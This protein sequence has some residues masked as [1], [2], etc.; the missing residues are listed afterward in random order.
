MRY[1]EQMITASDGRQLQVATLGEPTGRTVFF[2]HGTPGSASLVRTLAP[3]AESGELFVI[4]MSRAGYGTS[5]RQEGRTVANAAGDTTNVLDA[6]GREDYVVVGWSGGGP[7]ALACAALDAARCTAAWSIAG[8]VPISADIDWTEGMGPENLEEFALAMAGGPEYEPYVAAQA[9]HF[10]EATEGNVIEL[11]GGLLSD[12]DKATLAND[13]ARE[14]F[15]DSLRQGFSNGYFG[16]FDDDRAMLSEWGFDPATISIPVAVWYG[17]E[18][19]MVPSKHG[20]WLLRTLKN[21][22]EHHYPSEGH[23]SIIANHFDELTADITNA[24]KS[25]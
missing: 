24:T 8:V 1:E 13:D 14:L 4:T 25:S 10:A 15:A 7:H 2:H 5:S 16:F 6:L 23:L 21:V 22:N 18:D 12:P 17:N 20:E 9:A 19:L 3:L 11:F